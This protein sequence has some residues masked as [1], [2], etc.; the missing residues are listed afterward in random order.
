MGTDNLFH[1]RCAKQANDLAR[2]RASR[3]PYKKVLIVCEGEKTEPYYFKGLKNHYRLNSANVEIANKLGSDPISVFTHAQQRY[4]EEKNAGDPFDRVFCVFDKNS[5]SNYVQALDSIRRATP[6][7]TFISINSVPSF[8]YWLLLHF[9]C[10]TKP[11]S[12][13]NQVLTELQDHM[14]DYRKGLPDVFD[15][16]IEKLETAKRNAACVLTAAQKN[17]TDN[18]STRVHELVEF[19]QQ[20]SISRQGSG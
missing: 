16:L 12:V 18:P 8:E 1:K 4:R 7:N 5:H 2:R 11:Y 17:R 20:I 9:L 3:A 15:K 10:T 14:P 6:R 19:L 13:G